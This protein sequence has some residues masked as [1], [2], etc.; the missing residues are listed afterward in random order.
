MPLT[1]EIRLSLIP[2]PP[3]RPA[4]VP[5]TPSM[6]SGGAGS[7]GSPP[8]I[9]NGS[10]GSSR[11]V[12]GGHKSPLLP[13]VDD[14]QLPTNCTPSSPPSRLVSAIF[15]LC[16]LSLSVEIS[17]GAKARKRGASSFFFCFSSLPLFLPLSPPF[18]ASMSPLPPSRH[19]VVFVALLRF[20]PA[21][22]T[23]WVSAGGGGGGGGWRVALVVVVVVVGVVG[24]VVKVA[25]ASSVADRLWKGC[26]GCFMPP[27]RPTA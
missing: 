6:A 10:I 14:C 23:S 13:D 9:K 15:S 20:L 8:T 12:L 11:Q 21:G 16:R 5:L 7:G 18:P 17:C 2:S 1:P 3:S 24:V 25:A 22:R 27:M 4:P 26:S 19:R